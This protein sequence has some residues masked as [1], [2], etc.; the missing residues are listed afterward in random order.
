LFSI[1]RGPAPARTMSRPSRF[2]ALA[3]REFRRYFAGQSIA[4]IGGFA[5]NIGMAWLAYRLTG[6]VAVLGAVGFAQLA[7]TLIVSVPGFSMRLCRAVQHPK[8]P[9]RRATSSPKRSASVC[10]ASSTC[11]P[12]SSSRSG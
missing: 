12:A 6:S 1:L 2:P 4:L 7:P 3:H 8:K 5:H 10:C 9:R 11:A